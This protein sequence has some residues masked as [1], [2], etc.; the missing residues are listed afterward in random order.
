MIAVMAQHHLEFAT[1]LTVGAAGGIFLLALILGVWKYRQMATSP[2]HLAHPY[3]DIAHRAALMYSF[4]TLLV[5]VFVEFSDWPSAINLTAAMVL[6]FFFVTAILAYI[7]HG[8][9]RDTT[10]QYEHATPALHA[11]TVLL[12]I[13][14]IGGFAVLLAGFLHAQF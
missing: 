10:N 5:A 2:E 1:A 4:A 9:R 13:G 14:E 8:I 12:A 11:G 6:V 3:V 7:G